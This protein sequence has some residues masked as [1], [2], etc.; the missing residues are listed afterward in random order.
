MGALFTQGTQRIEVVVRRDDVGAATAG[1]GD[2][3]AETLGSSS[4][5]ASSSGVTSSASVSGSKVNFRIMATK[6]LAAVV[7]SGRLWLNY[8]ISGIA[9]KTGDT[10]LQEATQRNIEMA[11]EGAGILL[12]V[13][14]GATYAIRGGSMAMGVGAVLAAATTA[15]SLAVKYLGKEREFNMKVFKEENAIEYKRARA[16]LSLTTGRLR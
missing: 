8:A 11:E 1:A 6:T 13:G 7:A 3:S 10:A 12:S 2:E 16:N 15:T 14:L 5:G 9:Y 4:S